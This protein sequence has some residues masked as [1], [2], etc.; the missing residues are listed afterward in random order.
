MFDLANAN[1]LNLYK[2]DKLA[3]YA[4]CNYLFLCSIILKF[5]EM[6]HAIVLL[7]LLIPTE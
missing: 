4:I 2:I 1:N 5:P 7:N 3:N 6:I